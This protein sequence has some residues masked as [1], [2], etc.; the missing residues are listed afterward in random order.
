MGFIIF[1]S[2]NKNKFNYYEKIFL[3]LSPL[4]I[5]LLFSCGGDTSKNRKKNKISSTDSTSLEFK[6]ESSLNQSEPKPST[7]SITNLDLKR[8]LIKLSHH[9]NTSANEYLPVLAADENKM[10]F[11]AMD[12]TGFFDF[13]VDY[14]KQKSSGGEDLLVLNL[15]MVFGP[16]PDL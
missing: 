15:K 6:E 3:T 13:K 1:S 5:F 11:S 7:S 14:T 8:Q 16:M 12:R 9:I 10:Y 4:I 2:I